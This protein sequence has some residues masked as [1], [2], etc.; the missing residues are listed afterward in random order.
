MGIP[1]IKTP[2]T[3]TTSG[4]L[5]IVYGVMEVLG[6]VKIVDIGAALSSMTFND[7]LIPLVGIIAILFDEEST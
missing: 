5:A 6:T 4:I 3:T 7:L 1:K 2:Q